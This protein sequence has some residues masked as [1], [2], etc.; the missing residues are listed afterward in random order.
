MI[1]LSGAIYDP[2]GLDMEALTL[3][4]VPK[5]LLLPGAFEQGMCH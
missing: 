1:T 5:E 2:L 3:G 4:G